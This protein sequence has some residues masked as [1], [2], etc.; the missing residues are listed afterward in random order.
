MEHRHDE[1]SAEPGEDDGGFTMDFAIE[2]VEDIEA[3]MEEMMRLGALGYF[4]EAR[5]VSQSIA[6]E[7]QQKFE[8]VFEQLRLMLDQGAYVDLIARAESFPKNACTPE[9]SALIALM[10]AITHLRMNDTKETQAFD[11]ALRQ[12]QLLDIP[13]IHTRLRDRLKG[14]NWAIEEVHSSLVFAKAC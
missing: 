2:V 11:D 4:K 13:A 7:Y 6:P 10:V 5:Q 9:Q 3:Q 8:V 1:I 14:G 12:S